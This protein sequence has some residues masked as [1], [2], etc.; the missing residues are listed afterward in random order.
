MKIIFLFLLFSFYI[1]AKALPYIKQVNPK[2]FSGLWYEIARTYNSFEAN[3]VAATVEYKFINNNEYK[4]FNR[5]FEYEIGGKLIEYRG[6]ATALEENSM[7]RIKMTYYWIFS[8]DYRVLYLNNYKNAV[9]VS[10][11]LENVWIINREAFIKKNE[12]DT[13]LNYLKN[14]IDISSLIFT[15]QDKEGRY[16]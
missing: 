8:K 15:P 14:Y 2:S 9:V 5:C 7:S 10:D 13:I 11:D 3:C 12:L 4:V 1:K 16:K 6:V